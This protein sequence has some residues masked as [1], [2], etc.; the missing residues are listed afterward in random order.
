VK[1]LPN[2][3]QIEATGE[4]AG[5]LSRVADAKQRV[6]LT[7]KGK[8]VAA[9][10]PLEDLDSL[11]RPSP[12]AAASFEKLIERIQS[13][14]PKDISPET[15]ETDIRAALEERREERLAGGH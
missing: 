8:P 4:M 9:V 1:A 6:I 7:W 11:T 15:V 3:D 12:E 10:V 2:V 14:I 5:V 13:R